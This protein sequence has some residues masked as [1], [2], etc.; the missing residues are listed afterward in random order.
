MAVCLKMTKIAWCLLFYVKNRLRSFENG[1]FWVYFVP[2]TFLYIPIAASYYV[3]DFF[4]RLCIKRL[5]KIKVKVAENKIKQKGSYFYIKRLKQ[6][7]QV[8]YLKN[9]HFITLIEVM[10]V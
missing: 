3:S 5:P 10:G 1:F 6:F 2:Y 8:K 9:S 7:L 4:R